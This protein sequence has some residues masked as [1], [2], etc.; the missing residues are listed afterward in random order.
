VFFTPYAI[1]LLGNRFIGL[2]YLQAFFSVQFLAA[3][4]LTAYAASFMLLAALPT[5]P[6]A[7]ALAGCFIALGYAIIHPT[8]TEWSS[9]QYPPAERARPVALINTS[10]HCGAIIAVQSTGFLLPLLGWRSILLSIGVMI[11][12]VLAIVLA[13]AVTAFQISLKQPKSIA[14]LRAQ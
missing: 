4:G 11:L 10:Y 12:A 1:V 13:A 7:A 9:R 14:D 2:R 5:S 6:I 3:I 8:T